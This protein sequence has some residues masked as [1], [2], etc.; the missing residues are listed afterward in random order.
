M[1]ARLWVRAPAGGPCL[2]ICGLGNDVPAQCTVEVLQALSCCAVI[3]HD[4][5]EPAAAAFLRLFCGDVRRVKPGR[6]DALIAELSAAVAGDKRAAFVSVGHPMYAGRLP[7]L[8]ERAF[9]KRGLPVERFPQVSPSGAG[10]TKLEVS[11]GLDVAGIQACELGDVLRRDWTAHDGLPLVV[12]FNEKPSAEDVK[13]LAAALTRLYGGGHPLLIFEDRPEGLSLPTTPSRL[14]FARARLRPGVLLL[15]FP[16]KDAPK[17]PEQPL[18]RSYPPPPTALGKSVAARD[19]LDLCAALE[20]RLAHLD[21]EDDLAELCASF[22]SEDFEAALCARML[23]LLRNDARALSSARGRALEGK[24][25]SNLGLR[26]EAQ[27]AF[28]RAGDLTAQGKIWKAESLLI[29]GQAR[30][31]VAEARGAAEDGRASWVGF[32][33]SLARRISPQDLAR[34]AE[35]LKPSGLEAALLGPIQVLSGQPERGFQTFDAALTQK[36]SASLLLLRAALHRRQRA[37]AT[38]AADIEACLAREQTWQACVEKAL[39]LKL[40]GFYREALVEV[41]AAAV[42][43]GDAVLLDCLR[44]RIFAA[45]RLYADAEAALRRACEAEPALWPLRA[46]RARVLA[47]LS[48]A[49]EALDEIA[50]AASLSGKSLLNEKASVLALLGKDAEAVRLL[51]PAIREK[52]DA[53]DLLLR[54]RLHFHRGRYRAAERDLLAAAGPSS[55]ELEG[56]AK[57]ARVL[58]LLARAL[59]RLARP[60]RSKPPALVICGFGAISPNH[61]TLEG[62]RSLSRCDVIFSNFAGDTEFMRF[63]ELL[64]PDVRPMRWNLG[65]SVDEMAREAS[66]G[67]TVGFATRAHPLVYG[68]PSYHLIRRFK[69]LGLKYHVLNAVSSMDVMPVLGELSMEHDILGVQVFDSRVILAKDCRINTGLPLAVYFQGGGHADSLKDV[70]KALGAFYPK[71]QEC[72]TYDSPHERAR[73]RLSD[74][75]RSGGDV[76]GRNVLVVSPRRRPAGR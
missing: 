22:T 23:G 16:E 49:G 30:A 14:S 47:R 67:K 61:V 42:L 57:E 3:H 76:T 5:A 51:E 24:L 58:S 59:G 37:F 26:A 2:F 36:P 48:R 10:L 27:E 7:A 60:G 15:V 12:S 69:K 66:A 72:Y 52:R 38:G 8:L 55:G 18:E 64:A 68:N 39:L 75:L 74:L 43:G 28:A 46:Q 44:A 45:L 41:E 11:L 25:L 33:R 17:P 9:K 19:A 70:V 1:S 21:L 54:G 65:D 29:C 62:L 56:D 35:Q 32:L 50:A 40:M 31:A 34:F 53:R 73:L 4:L 63:L 71:D 13:K 6:E 20:L